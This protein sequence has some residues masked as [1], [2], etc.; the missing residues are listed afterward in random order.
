MKKP[1]KIPL[2]RM[3]PESRLPSSKKLMLKRPLEQAKKT[4][5]L[6]T[7]K[8]VANKY[9]RRLTKPNPR[10]ST[11]FVHSYKEPNSSHS[12][13]VFGFGEKSINRHGFVVD[14]ESKLKGPDLKEVKKA[15]NELTGYSERD[16]IELGNSPFLGSRGTAK[17]E[18]KKIQLKGEKVNEV[19]LRGAAVPS[20]NMNTL[21]IER[22]KRFL[23]E[24]LIRAVREFYGKNTVFIVRIPKEDSRIAS[25][26]ESRFIIKKTEPMHNVI[27][28]TID[29]REPFMRKE[30]P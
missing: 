28:L 16:L 21:N 18:V 15:F 1:P 13:A 26:L 12:L 2:N 3:P 7:A 8:S 30:K 4:I 17:V 11:K 27:S 20:H 19:T 10:N 24:N 25:Y 23:Y 22:S 14:I 5:S 6:K 29:F 9:F